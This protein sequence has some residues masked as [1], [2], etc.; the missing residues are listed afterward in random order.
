METM[1]GEGAHENFP[2]NPSTEDPFEFEF[3][4]DPVGLHVEPGGVVHFFSAAGEHTA[5]A[6]ATA[7]HE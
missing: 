1:P 2:I 7:Y 3:E 5:T 4:F 6:T